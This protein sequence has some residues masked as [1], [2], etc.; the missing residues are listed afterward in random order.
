MNISK[1]QL[2][3]GRKQQPV[4]RAS[5]LQKKTNKHIK[6]NIIEY[7]QGCPSYLQWCF[8]LPFFSNSFITY[9]SHHCD[10][11]THGLHPLQGL[12]GTS[13]HQFGTTPKELLPALIG[14]GSPYCNPVLFQFNFLAYVVDPRPL[15]QYHFNFWVLLDCRKFCQTF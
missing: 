12:N 15:W 9:Y 1:F 6:L 13:L 5:F 3:A 8:L 2:V 4:Q 14:Q 11:V 7:F 10:M